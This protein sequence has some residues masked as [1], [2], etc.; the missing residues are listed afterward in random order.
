M[1][2]LTVAMPVAGATMATSVA[3]VPKGCFSIVA[4]ARMAP[5][6]IKRRLSV[7]VKASPKEDIKDKIPEAIAE[8]QKTCED[9]PTSA[10]C[11]VAWDNVEELT[12]EAAHQRDRNKANSDPLE[13]YCA[14]NPETD[15]CRTYED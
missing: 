9:D 13:T 12:A 11:A 1:A 7:V 3:F 8:A 4:A 2:A 5:I 6:K 14:D 15:E 10:P